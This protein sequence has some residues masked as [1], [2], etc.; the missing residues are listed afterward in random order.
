LKEGKLLIIS[1]NRIIIRRRAVFIHDAKGLVI[2]QFD[3]QAEA[4]KI[5]GLNERQIA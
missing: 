5:L 3:S 2:N 1:E 4:A